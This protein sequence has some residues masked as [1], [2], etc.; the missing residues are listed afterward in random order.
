MIKILL[1]ALLALVLEANAAIV[2]FVP[3]TKTVN[4]G[5]SFAVTIGGTGFDTELLGGGVDL[6]FD[7]DVLEVIDVVIPET[8]DLIRLP[9]VVD[10]LAGTVTGTQFAQDEHPQIDTFPILEYWF[11]AKASGSSGL[12]LKEYQGN[13]FT[14]V[15]GSVEVT[16]DPGKVD[17]VPEPQVAW[18]LMGGLALLLA[19]VRIRTT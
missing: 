9:G 15:S 18:L 17:V 10:N 3:V 13:P 2:S 1:F 14:S 8:W 16:F 7:P 11:I 19:V 4:E 5:A 6:K 12:E